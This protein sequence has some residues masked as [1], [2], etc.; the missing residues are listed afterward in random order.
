MLVSL[1]AQLRH[2]ARTAAWELTGPPRLRALKGL[3][4]GLAAFGRGEKRILRAMQAVERE[5]RRWESDQDPW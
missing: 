3:V 2:L 1:S 5:R 4:G